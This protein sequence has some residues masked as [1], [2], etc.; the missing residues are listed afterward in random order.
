MQNPTVLILITKADVGGAQIHVLE[1]I[2]RLKNEFTFILATGEEDFLTEQA[3]KTGIE[4][5]VLNHLKRPIKFLEDKKAYTEC[6][7]LFLDV[8]PDLIH[9]HSSKAGVIG[10]LA[11]WRLGIPS[12]FTAHGWAFTEGAPLLQRAY[13]FAIESLLCRLVG[14]VI[15]VSELDFK[16]ASRY[17]VGPAAKRFLVQN[18]VRQPEHIGH[19]IEHEALQIVSIGRLNESQKN[20]SM[21]ID[22]LAELDFPY[23]AKLI[24][25][26][27]SR[28]QLEN[29]IQHK[30]LQNQIHLTGEVID[31]SHYLANTDI[32]VLTSNYEG[33]PLSILE[34]MSYGLPIVACDVGGVKEAVLDRENG[35]LSKRGDVQALTQN[36]KILAGDSKL[37][38]RYGARSLQHYQDK[39]TAERMTNETR[40]VYSRAIKDVKH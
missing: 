32:F 13:G 6:I 26:G 37:R 4:V 2:E 20:Q 3:R 25:E 24:G 19:K 31:T 40:N 38:A 39:F 16:L 9:S 10:R 23:E 21:L 29:Q 5:R 11:A 36:I 28:Q 12:L 35:L 33:L 30:G 1:I 7:E 34:A 14:S 22:V 8:K 17:K 18:G 15:T 27:A